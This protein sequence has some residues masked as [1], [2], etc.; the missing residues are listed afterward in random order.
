MGLESNGSGGWVIGL[1]HR[2]P[3]NYPFEL[4]YGRA[5][6]K[7]LGKAA[8][9]TGEITTPWRVVMVGRELNTLVNSTILPNLCPPPDPAFFPGIKTPW[10]KPGRAVWRYVDGGPTG[11]EGMKEF[12]RWPGNSA[13]N[14]TSSKASGPSGRWRNAASS[15]NSRSAR[16]GVWFWRHSNQLR[17]PQAQD[18]FFSDAA[19]ARCGRRQDRLLRP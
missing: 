5:E 8:A 16:V 10:I 7:R 3:L 18:E 1:G 13:S 9:I 4:R 2:Q 12:S 14:I 17:T 19:R 6:G 15:S 11:V